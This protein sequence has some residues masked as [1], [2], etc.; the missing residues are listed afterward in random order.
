MAKVRYVALLR[1]INVGGNA[2]VNMSELRS[3]LTTA[4]FENVVSY[5]N[6][7]NLLFSSTT[8]DTERL[9]SDIE[10]I[11]LDRFKLRIYAVVV[12]GDIWK[13]IIENAPKWWGHD[14]TRKHNLIIMLKPFDM[15]EVMN[16]IG[17]LKPNIESAEPGDGVI[18]QSLSLQDFG[19]T[20]SGKLASNPI[21][22]QMTIRNYN[23]AIKILALLN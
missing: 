17:M 23:T 4:G 7:G 14:A 9:S 1:G 5:I 22:K 16:A 3:A 15:N 6:S 21:Y 2:K 20:T 11:I 8:S 18:Y 10:Q 12:P 19:K 13:K